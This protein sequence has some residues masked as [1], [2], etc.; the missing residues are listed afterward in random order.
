MTAPILSHTNAPR[1]H[2]RRFLVTGPTGG[3]GFFSALRL[4]SLGGDLV[5]AGRSRKRLEAA[6]AAIL[7]EHPDAGV[8]HVEIDLASLAS[9]EH[10]ADEI[11]A[12]EPLD[13]LMCNAGLIWTPLQREV[14][15]DGHELTL[16]TNAIG[17][18]ALAARILPRLR[19][20][21][22]IVWLGSFATR[23]YSPTLADPQLRGGYGSNR[24]YAQSKLA[25]QVI[26]MEWERRRRAAGHPVA[27]IV[28]HPGYALSG[29]AREVPGINEP[30]E[31]KRLIDRI[32]RLVTG[33]ASTEVACESQVL[34]QIA[35]EVNGGDY[36][37]PGRHLF[38][39]PT[40][41]AATAT[42]YRPETGARLWRSLVEWTGVEPDFS[43]RVADGE[44]TREASAG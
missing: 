21:A 35:P 27:S 29:L 44:A 14:S 42:T 8:E 3:L 30:D 37:G 1:Q 31:G 10:A 41:L 28:A 38:G 25:V 40:K 15:V 16:A 12:L 23:L 36:I 18:F 33:A 2:G 39:T 34:A 11:A 43:V 26:G 17:H 5:L 19:D 7:A 20:D 22:R 9:V 6:R 24:A 4:A 32:Q 13:G